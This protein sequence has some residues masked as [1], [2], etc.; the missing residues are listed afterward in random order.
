LTRSDRP[1]PPGG[2]RA[3]V[4]AKTFR[5]DLR[6]WVEQDRRTALRVLALIED[7][8]R[9]PFAGIG[10]PE[11]LKYLDPNTWSRRITDEHRLVYVVAA[12]RVTFVQGRYHY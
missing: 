6:W 3:S 10:R 7:V 9:D 1:A 4:F 12:D 2:D 5:E 11:P 8:M